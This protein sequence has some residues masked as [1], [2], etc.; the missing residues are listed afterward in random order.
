M[1]TRRGASPGDRLFVT[2]SVGGPAAALEMLRDGRDRSGLDLEAL[3][4]LA[5]LERPEP[6]LKFGRIVGRTRAAMAAI[7]LSDGLADAAIRLSEAAGLGVVVDAAAVPVHAGA[8]QWWSARDVDPVPAAMAG[9]EDYELAFAVRPRQR[10][11]FS[12][13]CAALPGCSGHRRG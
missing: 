11:P 5:R 7:D 10:S 3:D 12:R 2:G 13:G 1:L 8:I 9:G 4:C 6:R